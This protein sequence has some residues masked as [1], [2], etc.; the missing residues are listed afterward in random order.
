MRIAKSK[1]TENNEIREYTRYF[2]TSLSDIYE[3]ADPVRKHWLIENQ[4]HWCLDVI[5]RED[6]SRVR[7]DNSPLNMNILR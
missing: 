5:I 4:L 3:F 6:S 7:K 2:I 1:I